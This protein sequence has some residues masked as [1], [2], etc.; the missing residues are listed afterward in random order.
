MGQTS[1]HLQQS[2]ILGCVSGLRDYKETF[3]MFVMYLFHHKNGKINYEKLD[4]T[5]EVLFIPELN[6]ALKMK[7]EYKSR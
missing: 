6:P 7:D 3:L 5:L 2:F 1:R 4:L